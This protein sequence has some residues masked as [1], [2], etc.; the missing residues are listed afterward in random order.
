MGDTKEDETASE[1]DTPTAD[2][3]DQ[4]ENPD[5]PAS[6]I[7]PIVIAVCLIILIG[8]MS[9]M[10]GLHYKRKLP[11]CFYSMFSQ[12]WKPVMNND[13]FPQQEDDEE[14]HP[15]I[16][17]NGGADD[18]V[19]SELGDGEKANI[20]ND[21]TTVTWTSDEKDEKDEKKDEEKKEEVKEEKAT[22]E[23]PLKEEENLEK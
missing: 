11:S 12:R 18:S 8:G 23:T 19:L 3:Q 22:E 9:I 14:R 6:P 4:D 2:A 1:D 21:L 13:D 7:I 5:K 10:F 17:K 15:S 20:N 16:I